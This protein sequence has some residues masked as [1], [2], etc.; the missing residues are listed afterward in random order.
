MPYIFAGLEMGMGL[1]FLGAVAGEFVG[2]SAGLGCVVLVSLETLN[3][4]Q[5][6]AVIFMLSTLGYLMHRTMLE[7]Q[8]HVVYWRSGDRAPI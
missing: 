4:S 8:K 7:I 1:A 3:L 6:F 2:G 5:G